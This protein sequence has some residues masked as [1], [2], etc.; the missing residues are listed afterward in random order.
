MGMDFPDRA[1]FERLLRKLLNH[2]RKPAVL[3]LDSYRWA[4]H[5]GMP[6]RQHGPASTPGSCGTSPGDW[7]QPVC[8][9]GLG[10]R[11]C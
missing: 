1:T 4:Q 7:T 10:L 2:P 11:I 6:P 3:L 9:C 8:L 5:A